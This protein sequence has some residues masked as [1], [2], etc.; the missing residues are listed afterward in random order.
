MKLATSETP[1]GHY[2]LAR[3]FVGPSYEN[4]TYAGTLA[5]PAE[6][7]EQFLDAL[8]HGAAMMRHGENP[9]EVFFGPDDGGEE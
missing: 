4:N 6:T 1:N 7:W 2:T 9:L 3:M 5:L 8:V